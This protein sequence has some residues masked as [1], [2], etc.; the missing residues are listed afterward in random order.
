MIQVSVVIPYYNDALNV[1]KC[2]DSIAVSLYRAKGKF[3]DAGKMVEVIIID[4]HSPDA[5][6]YPTPPIPLRSYRL[7]VNEGVG[8]ARNRGVEKAKGDYILFVDSDILL[9]DNHF[10]IIFDEISMNGNLS[11]LQGPTGAEPAND[12]PDSFQDYLAAAWNYY[13]EQ[14]WRITVF[15]QCVLVK[16]TFFIK[17]GG[18]V[19]KFSRSGGEEFEFALRVGFIKGAHILF[20]PD[21][22]HYH[23]FDKIGKRLKK[24]YF[25]SRYISGIAL[26]MPNLPFSFKAQAILRSA[27]SQILNL[28]LVLCLL[29]P[30]KGLSLYLMTGTLFYFSDWSFSKHMIRENSIMLSALSVFYRQA[31][32][33]F[34]N[35]GMVA[36]Y[37]NKKIWKKSG[38][39]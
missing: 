22:I 20:K 12:N 29:A 35:L 24:V 6:S 16:K 38:T 4:D 32:Y 8:T 25:R 33:T 21:L 27:F 34:I 18:F 1:K 31:E 5:F 17:M 30:V 9:D 2:I 3:P 14:N 19:E 15:T 39:F 10:N 23:H 26:E 28:C 13:E 36:G 37:V 7:P 11:I